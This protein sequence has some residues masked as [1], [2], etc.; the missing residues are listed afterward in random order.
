MSSCVRI[1]HILTK[2]SGI[3]LQ[4]RPTVPDAHRMA[5][6]ENWDLVLMDIDLLTAMASKR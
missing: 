4:A 6:Q 3:G 5:R 1:K 2:A